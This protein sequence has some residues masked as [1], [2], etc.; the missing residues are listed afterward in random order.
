LHPSGREFESRSGADLTDIRRELD[1]KKN[2]SLRISVGPAPHPVSNLLPERTV[3][4]TFH[5]AKND[6]NWPLCFADEISFF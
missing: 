2:N 6:L 4:F 1:A 5:R 3:Q